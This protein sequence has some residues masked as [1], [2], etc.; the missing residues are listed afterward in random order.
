MRF[1]ELRPN[2]IPQNLGTRTRLIASLGRLS[3]PAFVDPLENEIGV[4][5]GVLNGAL[6]RGA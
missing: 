1:I 3:R 6:P 2:E 5:D 4:R